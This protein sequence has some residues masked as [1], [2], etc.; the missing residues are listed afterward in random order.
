MRL[1]RIIDRNYDRIED[2]NCIPFMLTWLREHKSIDNPD[3]LVAKRICKVIKNIAQDVPN[4][5]NVDDLSRLY[6]YHVQAIISVQ[7][8]SKIHTHNYQVMDAH[9]HS[10]ASD[11][12]YDIWKRTKDVGWLEDAYMISK[13]GVEKSIPLDFEHARVSLRVA[14]EQ[15]RILYKKTFMM[16]IN[17]KNFYLKL[18]V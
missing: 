18:L 5:V 8:H 1:E 11:V 14:C 13:L 10:H 2:R 12:A 6:D 16:K 15:G 3:P 7:S 17:K 9:L 4:Q